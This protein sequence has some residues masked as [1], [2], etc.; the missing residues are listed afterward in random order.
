[1]QCHWRGRLSRSIVAMKPAFHVGLSRFVLEST[2]SSGDQLP[3]CISGCCFSRAFDTSHDQLA[4]LPFQSATASGDTGTPPQGL[5]VAW[6]V[7]LPQRRSG[8]LMISSHF[9]LELS[10]HIV[11]ELRRLITV[12]RNVIKSQITIKLVRL[13]QL[14]IPSKPDSFVTSSTGNFQQSFSQWSA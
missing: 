1:M 12:T 13:N 4:N 14:P 7:K 6:R 2:N 5:D 11:G 3:L 9:G 10:F 8:V